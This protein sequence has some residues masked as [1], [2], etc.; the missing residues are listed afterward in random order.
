MSQER[1]PW[2]HAESTQNSLR[3]IGDPRNMGADPWRPLMSLKW[4][5]SGSEEPM[6][7]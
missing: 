6:A 5:Q 2:A 7:A 1:H 3:G 4:R